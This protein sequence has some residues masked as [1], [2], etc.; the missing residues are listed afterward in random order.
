MTNERVPTLVL[1][2]AA[3]D[4]FLVPQEMLER[5]RVPAEH[6]A[7]VGQLLTG[8]GGDDVQGFADALNI[9]G[10][11]LFDWAVGRTSPTGGTTIQKGM[12]G[13]GLHR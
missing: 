8:A 13:G 11:L 6:N 10:W 7:E 1:K 3:G 12:L 9:T 4:Y 5:G 2:D